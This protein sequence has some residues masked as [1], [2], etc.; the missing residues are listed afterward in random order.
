[1]I[2][3][4]KLKEIL[5]EI[6]KKQQFVSKELKACPPGTL[7]QTKERGRIVYYHDIWIEAEVQYK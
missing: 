2:T 6:Q 1:M 5:T 4:L 7:L 3:G